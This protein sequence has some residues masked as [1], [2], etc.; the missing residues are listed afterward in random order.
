MA[1]IEA[2]TTSKSANQ[3]THSRRRT[4]GRVAGLLMLTLGLLA[5][6]GADRIAPPLRKRSA[7]L[8]PLGCA[9][10]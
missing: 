9:C 1:T 10:D 8:V 3:A 7:F 2:V 4:P 5:G 6:V